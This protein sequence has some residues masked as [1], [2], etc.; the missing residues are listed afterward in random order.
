M[1][2]P[3]CAI[4]IA[5]PKTRAV[6]GVVEKG[7][8]VSACVCPPPHPAPLPVYW[9]G[10]AEILLKKRESVRDVGERLFYG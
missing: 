10:M 2:I 3:C 6:S 8:S 1:V 5:D 9:K 7:A 4:L